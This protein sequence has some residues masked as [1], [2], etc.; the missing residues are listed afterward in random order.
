MDT[1]AVTISDFHSAIIVSRLIHNNEA[2]TVSVGNFKREKEHFKFYN[3]L[4]SRLSSISKCCITPSGYNDSVVKVKVLKQLE[5]SGKF[6]VRLFWSHWYTRKS[7][8][9]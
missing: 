2:T 1:R 9:Q 4:I 5:H 8:V 7:W 6:R 3:F